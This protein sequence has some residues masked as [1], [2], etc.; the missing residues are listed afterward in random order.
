M[1]SL[2]RKASRFHVSILGVALIVL[3]PV[4]AFAQQTAARP[5]RG[6]L[7]GASYSISDFEN[8]SLTNGNL[9]MSIP[10]ASLPPIAGGK[11]KLTLSAVYNS[12][13]WNITRTENQL[14][15]FYNCAT[16]V[17]DTPQLSER[18]GWQISG[19]Y[20]IQFRE[21][22]EDFNYVVPQP[23]NG[24][25]CESNSYENN[26]LRNYNW[27]RVVLITPDGAEHDLRPVDNSNTYTGSRG[28]LW[29]HYRDTPQTLN[30]PMRYYSNDGS[31][32]YA[33]INPNSYSTLWTIYLNDGTKVVQTSDG[34]QRITDT[35][36][37]S[38]K[39]FG[40]ANGVAHFQDEQTAR[41]IKY[42]YDPA[43]NNGQGQGEV[44]YQTVGGTWETVTINFGVTQVQ[45]KLYKIN[46]WDIDGGENG[47]GA[48][49]SYYGVFGAEIPVIREIIY[50]VTE[51]NVAP[52]RFTF[53]YNSDSTTSNV[54]NTVHWACGAT[55]ETYS[56]TVSNGM[57][58][59]SRVVTPSG[60]TIDYSYSRDGTH[61]FYLMDGLNDV[62][63]ETVTQKQVTHDGVTETWEYDIYET[64]ACGGT[65][66]GPDGSIT[67]ESCFPSD[68]GFGFPYST[69][70]FSGRT[71]N[72]IHSGKERIDRHW[73][74]LNF[75]G[76]SQLATGVWN[77]IG[78]FNPVVDAEYLS[79]LDG[80]GNRVKMSAKTFQYDYNGNVVE[81]KEYDWFDPGSVTFGDYGV[82]TGVPAG[83]TALR[84][85]T[86]SYYNAATGSTSSNV[87]AKRSLTYATPLILNALKQTTTG[88][89]ITQLSYDGNSYG[90][91]PTIGNLTS[92]SVYNDVED[93]W[94][95]TSTTYNSY[96]NVTS[97][98]DGRGKVT[99]FYYDDST[100][101]APTRV[102][103]DPQNGT[104]SQTATTE[105]DFYTGL[106]TATIDANLKRTDIDYTNQL[107]N[108]VD[109]FGRPGIVKDPTVN[110]D[111]SNQRHRV[112]TTYEDSLRRVTTA[113]D[114]YAENDKL[115]KTRTTSD[116]LGRP[117]L[118]EQTEDGTNYTI[119][120]K[121][122]Y[123]TENRITYSSS[124]MRCT[125]ESNNSCSA[126]PLQYVVTA[127]I[128]S[129]MRVTNDVLGRPIEVATFA[130]ATQPTA[131]G[132]TNIT[133]TVTTAY[134]ANFTTVTDQ[135]LKVRRSMTDGLGRLV[136]VD[137][138]NDSGS[139][140]TT[141]SPNQATSYDYDVF[142]NLLHVYQGSQTRTFAYD[143]LSRLRTAAN[144][145]S[146]T[147]TYTYDENG[148]LLTKVDARSITTTFV[149]DSL[150][151]V[152]SR[153]YSDSTPDVTYT[154]D[155]SGIG[156]GKGR[157]ASVSSSVSSYSYS[158]Y[159]SAGRVQGGIQTI[160]S[161]TY[162]TT[163][164]YDLAGH[165]KTITYPSTHAVTYNYDN[166]GRLA[167][168][169]TTN[170]AFT[171]NLGDGT[172]RTYAKGTLYSATGQMT[173]EQYGTTTAIY[174]KL[175]YNSRGQI[176]EIL[177]STSG[178]DTTFNRGKLVND[179]GTTNNNGN[180]IKQTVYIPNDDANT[181]P[182]S[183]YQRYD[184]DNLNRVGR[185]QEFNSNDT[186]LWKQ[187]YVYDR[188]GNRTIDYDNTTN[189]IPRPQFTVS[190]STNRLG[191]PSGQS[192]AMSYDSVGNLTMDT[193][194][195]STVSRVY[196]AENKMTSETT[197]NSVV[198]GSYSY[199]GDGRR[200]KRVVGSAET[201]QVYGVVGEL[202]AEYAANADDST[203]KKEYG[204]RNNEL[205]VTVTVGSGSAPTFTDN[206]LEVGGTLIKAVHITEL[207]TA[208]NQARAFAGLSAASWTD[209]SLTG[210]SI[211]AVHITELRTKLD[212][213]RAALG[214]SAV[215][216]TDSSLSG[217]I[218]KAVH[219][220][221]LR[222]KVSE[223]VTAT[224]IRWLVADQLGTPRMVFDQTGSLAGVNRH[225]YL[226]FGEELFAGTGGRTTA[227]G[228]SASDGVRQKFTDK[229]RDNETGLD[230]FFSRYYSST[231]GRFL[232]PD[233]FPGGAV[234]VFA[235]RA[236]SNPTFYA[237]LTN[238]ETLNKYQYCLNSP[239]RYVD[240]YGHQSQSDNWLTQ[241]LGSLLRRL[242]AEKD[243]ESAIEE[244]RGPLSL[245]ADK[246]RQQYG[247]AFGQGLQAEYDLLDKTGL[248]L[249]A[250][251]Y[252]QSAIKND[253]GETAV[254]GVFFA[255][256]VATL[257]RGEGGVTIG[258]NMS[259]RVIPVATEIGAKTYRPTSKIVTN[260]LENN[261]R[262]ISSQISRGRRI[263]D[264]GRDVNREA[265]PYY[266]KE[267]EVLT[268]RGLQR[269][270][271]GTVTIKKKT[272]ELYEWVRKKS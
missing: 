256:N 186:L 12:K 102:V 269:V 38:I 153:N 107:L 148:N 120:S 123:D 121:K 170:L 224:D 163:Y 104:G 56:R 140:G 18:G 24:A 250:F 1:N 8:I 77:S 43:G 48:P 221:E 146:G 220:S 158:G 249:G 185:V 246:V 2:A 193:Y 114:L 92:A 108:A 85:T 156:N 212:E 194:S 129:W 257:G 32:I 258:E 81:T 122:V 119:F 232:S 50:P 190:T 36:G 69:G 54:S 89:A 215:T 97:T 181:G 62:P 55:P 124:P 231:H 234:E 17:V 202:L 264:I 53:G 87:Y 106:V 169:D 16:W 198:A 270:R 142:G 22:V 26:A 254:A 225:D 46:D 241:W 25:T 65:V 131:T 91:A 27:Y 141:A 31:F 197:Y 75:D 30:Q 113:S 239:L 180:L 58:A 187:T 6:F 218:V 227:Q 132:T 259:E 127:S 268:R 137:E 266:A 34:V 260:W 15:P 3:S 138:P 171:G 95:T 228:Y 103:V 71:V 63:R 13:L 154:Y 47:T 161:Q 94:I 125:I 117:V 252:L 223:T 184:Y 164:T 28:Y 217:V 130:G 128:N 201:W 64:T 195:G 20:G 52:R 83:A 144:P 14:E 57:G 179:Y 42:S 188:Y 165:V 45:G 110:V 208:V 147:A 178:G 159:D 7:P 151:R 74:S 207:R 4:F 248:D 168:K 70:E 175:S 116:K 73:I 80:S 84:T 210:F 243:P 100:H 237:D 101:A 149:Y 78:N 219:I 68:P 29:G 226:P 172:T 167:D 251:K 240:P 196:D 90:T 267:V 60:A 134:D 214:L 160:G 118:T 271:V 230:Y 79:L 5:D 204:Y 11:L 9:N 176:A 111:G 247:D 183:W 265:S 82:P 255:V 67:T 35:N 109:P 135:A 136:R 133:G 173:Q 98:T 199:D 126:D 51:P 66:T 272:Y 76:G 242:L 192:G 262:W 261:G 93:N 49:C 59:L 203:P 166:A 115:L 235:E 182:T 88:P 41:E 253:E 233:E 177:A 162:T 200:V 21:G 216:W 40:D 150:N 33:I 37:N 96:G 205:L 206:P 99:N 61:N 229:Q 238:P 112:T 157:L 139:L 152:T 23:L 145:E 10:L 189:G 211:K 191:V 213:A 86:S 39:M 155:S 19:G 245:G 222:T 236:S 44:E 143:S 72:S 244:K 174:H 263:F 105:Y 209:S